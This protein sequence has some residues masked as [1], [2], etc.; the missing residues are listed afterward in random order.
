[1]AVVDVNTKLVGLLGNPLGHSFSPAMHN[2]A[3]ET[4]V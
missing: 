2:K 4:L 3:F 1:M